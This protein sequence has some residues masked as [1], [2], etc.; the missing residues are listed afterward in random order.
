MKKNS[1]LRVL[2]ISLVVRK[3]IQAHQEWLDEHEDYPTLLFICGNQNTE[4]RIYRIVN[5]G[6]FEFEVMTTTEERL[7]GNGTKI[8]LHEYDPDWDEE[9]E[10]K[11]F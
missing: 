2:T 5:N 3:R 6:Y 8:W 9:M 11:R 1:H 4:R 10:F 7:A